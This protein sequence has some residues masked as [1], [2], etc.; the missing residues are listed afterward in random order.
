MS[1]SSNNEYAPH[2]LEL[3]AKTQ[4]MP[5]T[6]GVHLATSEAE[7]EF[8]ARVEQ[9][10]EAIALVPADDPS[11]WTK[12]KAPKVVALEAIL[13]FQI[14]EAERDAAFAHSN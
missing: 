4:T 3:R 14:T 11:S 5:T 9:I 7:S 10:R 1:N 6:A 8:L 2:S 12:T 13:G